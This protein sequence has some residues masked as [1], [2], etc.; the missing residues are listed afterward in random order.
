VGRASSRREAI[1]HEPAK[2]QGERV[3]ECGGETARAEV[4]G[5]QLYE[6]KGAEAQDC[7]ESDRPIQRADSDQALS[8]AYLTDLLHHA[9]GS[10]PF[11]IGCDFENGVVTRFLST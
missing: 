8:N 3:E 1:H 11:P 5:I 6:R 4:S 7:A 9:G 10:G 2:A